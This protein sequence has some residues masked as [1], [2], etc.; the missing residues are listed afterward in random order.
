MMFRN[1]DALD[2]LK[3]FSPVPSGA[4]RKLTTAI[5]Y[6]GAWYEGGREGRALRG[7]DPLNAVV[8]TA[9]GVYEVLDPA[10]AQRIAT[11]RA[12]EYAREL[13]LGTSRGEPEPV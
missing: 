8:L 4:S 11:E 13:R 3:R 1:H 7:I 12:A 9:H 6:G 5:F 2:A 10:E